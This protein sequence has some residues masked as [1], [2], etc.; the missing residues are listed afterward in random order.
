MGRKRA[1][2]LVAGVTA[3][4][5]AGI[6]VHRAAL[7]HDQAELGDVAAE[8][9]KATHPEW[10]VRPTG[11]LELE[12][13]NGGAAAVIHLDNAVREAAGDREAFTA[14]VEQ[15]V[16]NLADAFDDGQAMSLEKV[17]ERLRPVLVPV[18]FA[19]AQGVTRRAFAGDV[20]E[21][22]VVDS[23]KR[24]TYVTKGQPAAWKVDLDALHD[25]AARQ[26][27][28]SAKADRLEPEQSARGVPGKLLVIAP[29]DHYAAA[30]LLVHEVRDAIARELGYPFFA[31][32]PNRDALLV[33]SADYPTARLE[34]RAED[35]LA[36]SSYPIS[37]Q[38]FRVDASGVALAR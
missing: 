7:R 1:S 15:T 38:I 3:L 23:P 14:F 16:Q 27:W 19:D 20:V 25:E 22:F 10:T 12:V 26:L 2:L 4:L 11:P 36:G 29:G 33:C 18:S 21:T 32:V 31:A 30:R 24:M 6:V 34:S 37:A 8:L 17:R 5:V 13:R 28:Q 35:E 9:L